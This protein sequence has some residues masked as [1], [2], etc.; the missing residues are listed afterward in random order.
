MQIDHVFP[1]SSKFSVETT[2]LAEL[3]LKGQAPPEKLRLEN[4]LTYG[5]ETEKD[6]LQDLETLFEPYEE[7]ARSS[8]GVIP[9]IQDVSQPSPTLTPAPLPF[10]TPSPQVIARRNAPAAADGNISPHVLPCTTEGLS[11]STNHQNTSTPQ[12]SIPFPA[13]QS[14]FL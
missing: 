7:I 3:L 14:W 12:S 4:N 5:E 1:T 13:G 9:P 10:S 11:T 8:G 6:D 2:A